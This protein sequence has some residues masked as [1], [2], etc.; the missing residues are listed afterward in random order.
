MRMP[1]TEAV[2]DKGL[3]PQL[4]IVGVGVEG[5]AIGPLDEPLSSLGRDGHW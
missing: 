3:S 2:V 5:E 4:K 1:T